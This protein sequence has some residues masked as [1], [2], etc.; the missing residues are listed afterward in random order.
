MIMSKKE[1]ADLIKKP[2][3]MF[4]IGITLIIGYFIINA[5]VS[6][7]AIEKYADELFEIESIEQI[8]LNWCEKFPLANKDAIDTHLQFMQEPSQVAKVSNSVKTCEPF[9]VFMDVMEKKDVNGETWFLLR[10]K[11]GEVKKW[12]WQK[13]KSL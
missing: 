6:D 9:G 2:S 11:N 1:W 5:A 13:E 8:N 3:S 10:W 4:A 7:R 12:G